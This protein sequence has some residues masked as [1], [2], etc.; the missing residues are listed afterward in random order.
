MKYHSLLLGGLTAILVTM[1]HG[2]HAQQSDEEA[3]VPPF[4]HYT[5]IQR[6]DPAS[7]VLFADG[8]NYYLQPETRIWIGSKEATRAEL[9]PDM[10]GMN[11]GLDAYEHESRY[12]ITMLHILKDENES[13]A[14]DG[15]AK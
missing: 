11:I 2:I 6:L 1:P 12:L 13:P 9:S 5:V 10:I 3:G 4:E 15:G 7:G 8:R 14:A